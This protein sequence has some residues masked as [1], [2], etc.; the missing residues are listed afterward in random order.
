MYTVH[1][2]VHDD[3][4]CYSDIGVTDEGMI[5]E[6]ELDYDENME[7]LDLYPTGSLG[8]GSTDGELGISTGVYSMGRCKLQCFSRVTRKTEPSPH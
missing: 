1:N 3:C 5:G 7:G 8:G 4:L 6:E 2:C